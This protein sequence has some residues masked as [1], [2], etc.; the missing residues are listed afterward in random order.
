MI[1]YAQKIQNIAIIYIYTYRQQL[2]LS[3]PQTNECINCNNMPASADAGM[4]QLVRD[5]KYKR[6]FMNPTHDSSE[7]LS[8]CLPP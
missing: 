4:D 3:V 1:H 7:I 5:T 8:D 2:L 6:E